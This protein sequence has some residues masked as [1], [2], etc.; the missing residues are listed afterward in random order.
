MPHPGL[1]QYIKI[2][3]KYFDQGVTGLKSQQLQK[4]LC[5]GD[6]NIGEHYTCSSADF[7]MTSFYTVRASF[8][9]TD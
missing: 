7:K 3:T 5:T 6:E 4:M 2:N 9:D 8:L 1:S